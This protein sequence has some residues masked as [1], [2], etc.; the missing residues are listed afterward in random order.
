MMSDSAIPIEDDTPVHLLKPEA[1]TAK[2]GELKAQY[3]K[4][5]PGDEWTAGADAATTEL[6][7]LAKEAAKIT[8]DPVGAGLVGGL[9]S[10][11]MVPFGPEEGQTIAAQK[12]QGAI[13][14]LREDFGLSDGA[15]REALEPHKHS[16][17]PQEREAVLQLEGRLHGDKEWRAS[18]L[19]GNQ[20]AKEQLA[21]IET[22][23]LLPVNAKEA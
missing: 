7:R 11:T 14:S 10:G 21:L 1:A 9:P 2:L 6:G 19:G 22:A 17:T 12:L 23:K 20:R 8:A 3:A 5:N 18:L 4:Q 13:T 15:I 16:I